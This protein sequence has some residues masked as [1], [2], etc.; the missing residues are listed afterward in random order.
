MAV[1]ELDTWDVSEE[2]VAL[3]FTSDT[4]WGCSGSLRTSGFSSSP[5]KGGACLCAK[6]KQEWTHK[7]PD[8]QEKSV[9]RTE[10]LL[11]L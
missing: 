10:S 2:G 7:G 1:A 11:V 9:A 5:G 8:P 4:P 3:P 6:K